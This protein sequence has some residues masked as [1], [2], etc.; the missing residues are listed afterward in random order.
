LYGDFLDGGRQQA[1]SLD[2][3]AYTIQAALQNAHFILLRVNGM[4]KHVLRQGALP[5]ALEQALLRHR[6][7]RVY[8]GDV[9][10]LLV[11]H[12]PDVIRIWDMGFR[13]WVLGFSALAR[14]NI[15]I[16]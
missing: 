16:S 2:K 5:R 15:A 13:I 11:V 10:L 8:R 4:I 9:L 14:R 12:N 1:M 6:A 3:K 7:V